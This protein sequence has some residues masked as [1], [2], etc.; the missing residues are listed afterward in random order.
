MHDIW[1][2]KS[3]VLKYC[4]LC[5]DYIGCKLIRCQMSS[6]LSSLELERFLTNN[7]GQ[8]L[9]QEFLKNTYS[10]ASPTLQKKRE[11]KKSKRWGR[12]NKSRKQATFQ[13][14]ELQRTEN[15]MWNRFRFPKSFFTF[16]T[17]HLSRPQFRF[18]EGFLLF[19]IIHYQTEF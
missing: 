13:E 4:E 10:T 5:I 12:K 7:E 3:N 2:K 16:F 9:L 6:L 15:R 1:I 14:S 17:R 8:K 19:A 11:R 18:S